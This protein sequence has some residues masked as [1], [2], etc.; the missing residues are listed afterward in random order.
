[1][2][3]SAPPPLGR[4]GPL[5]LRLAALQ[6]TWPPRRPERV[7]PA[8]DA[9]GL[10]AGAAAADA[11]ADEG[12][13]LV[14]VSAGG[15]AGPA[16]ALLAVLLD[17]EP[18][19]AV[20]TAAAPG[21]AALVAEVRDGLRAAR[22]HRTDPEALLAAL[23]A[24]GLAGL[25]GLVQQC[26]V[27]RTPVLLSGA[28]GAW[29]AALLAE[30]RAPGTRDALIAGCSP[31]PGAPALALA[32][33]GLVPLLDLRWPGPRAPTSRSAS[34]SARS[35]WAR[36]PVRR[37]DG[38]RLALTTLTVLPVRGPAAL[39]RRTA[40]RAMALAPLVGL[41]LGARRRRRPAR[42]PRAR[43]ER[44]R[45]PAARPARRRRAGRPHPRPAPGRAG[46][47]GRRAGLVPAARAGPRGDEEPRRSAPS[48]SSPSCSCWPCRSRR[49]RPA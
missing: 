39:D 22:P 4:L 46:R 20:G 8:R 42:R 29:A 32:E 28:P 33:L 26:A 3:A 10:D 23:G 35:T 7:V 24:P 2:P 41:L 27:R 14:V 16:L 47:H 37:P 40:G 5:L 25:T 9:E 18:V 12:A 44:P 48:A 49:W 38:L 15:P 31:P 34:C 1:M 6:D 11:L 30:R 13:D 45:R 19:P 17:V 36:R 43:A 21:W